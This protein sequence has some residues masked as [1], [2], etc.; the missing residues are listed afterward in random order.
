MDEMGMKVGIGDVQNTGSEL[1]GGSTSLDRLWSCGRA[2]DGSAFW[3]LVVRSNALSDFGFMQTVVSAVVAPATFSPPVIGFD[4]QSTTNSSLS[5]GIFSTEIAGQG[6]SARANNGVGGGDVHVNNT[7]FSIEGFSTVDSVVTRYTYQPE[8]QGGGFL[9]STWGVHS[10][11]GVTR[12]KLGNVIDMWSGLTTATLGDTY[13]NDA[14]RQ[15][16]A[17]GGS[18]GVTIPWD[19]SVFVGA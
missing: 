19:G 3:Y 5:N 7:Q 1:V 12:G 14:T 4:A 2:S 9:M 11:D 6:A 13:P 18:A 17:L 16:L 10:E 8:L 15:F